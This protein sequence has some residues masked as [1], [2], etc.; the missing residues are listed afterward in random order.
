MSQFADGGGLA[1]KPYVSSAAYCRPHG[2]LLLRVPVQQESAKLARMLARSDALY[3][4]FYERHTP[5]LGHNARI[6]MAYQQLREENGPGDQR[7]PDGKGPR[8]P[9]RPEPALVASPIGACPSGCPRGS[10]SSFSSQH[11]SEAAFP[12]ILRWRGV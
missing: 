11:G 5:K 9:G 8:T 4:E 12:E 7:R 2:G 10:Q 3:W 1:T 6:G